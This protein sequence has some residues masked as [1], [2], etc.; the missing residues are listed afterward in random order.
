M[1]RD[2]IK[3]QAEIIKHIEEAENEI[4]HL[5]NA[6]NIGTVTILCNK[7]TRTYKELTYMIRDR[8]CFKDMIDT[9]IEIRETYIHFLKIDLE[10]IQ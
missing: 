10:K 2:K 6:R 1:D 7:E 4:R 9:L 8:Q 3:A 5:E